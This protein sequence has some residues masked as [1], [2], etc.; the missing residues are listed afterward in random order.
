MLK[1]GPEAAYIPLGPYIGHLIALYLLFGMWE[2]R[3]LVY[4]K[5]VVVG[6]GIG[7]GFGLGILTH[8]HSM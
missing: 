6:L 5:K 8:F 2:L 1:L 4:G 7:R 3:D